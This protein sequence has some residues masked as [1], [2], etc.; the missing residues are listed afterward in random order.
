MAF[1]K[2]GR[3]K[4][5]IPVLLYDVQ[6]SH[7]ELVGVIIILILQLTKYEMLRSLCDFHSVIIVMSDCV[8]CS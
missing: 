1:H 3:Y 6:S 7:G 4:I 2:G 5:V 8:W